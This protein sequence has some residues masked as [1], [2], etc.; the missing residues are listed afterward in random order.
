M[1][2]QPLSPFMHPESA[3]PSSVVRRS[4]LRPAEAGLLALALL[5]GG[6]ASAQAPVP[7]HLQGYWV[8]SAAACSSALGVL[9]A[10]QRLKLRNASQEKSFQTETCFSCEGGARYAGQVIWVLPKSE[11]EKMQ[12]VL[13]LNADERA[14]TARL[15]FQSDALSAAFPLHQTE[16]K[17]CAK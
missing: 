9:V 15:E 7:V 17:R 4:P 8:P 11:A 6:S 12:F 14:G 1:F 3:E 2:I 16:L 10:A 13:Y 5:T